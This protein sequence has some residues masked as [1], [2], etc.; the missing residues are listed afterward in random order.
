MKIPEAIQLKN[1][2]KEL[3]LSKADFRTIL[4]RT[5]LAEYYRKEASI[6]K[7]DRDQMDY[8]QFIIRELEFGYNKYLK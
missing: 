4:F 3:I 8:I 2:P 7:S 6:Y 1:R 5:Q